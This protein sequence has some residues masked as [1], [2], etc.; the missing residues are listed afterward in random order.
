[1]PAL[2]SALRGAI[3]VARHRVG[4]YIVLGSAQPALVRGV[5]ESLAGR[6]AVIE[7]DPLTASEAGA[8]PARLPWQA[9]WLKGGFPGC[10]ARRGAHVVGV[11]SAPGA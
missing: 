2:F 9:V 6:A 11:V 5:S 3:D 7:L 8:G 1:V 4:R 10:A